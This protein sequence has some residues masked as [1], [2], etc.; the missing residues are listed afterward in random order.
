MAGVC[1]DMTENASLD[2]AHLAAAPIASWRVWVMPVRDEADYVRAGSLGRWRSFSLS[3]R[4][5]AS[6]TCP[7]RTDHACVD[8]TVCFPASYVRRAVK[9]LKL[10]GAEG[11]V[12]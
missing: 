7:T 10:P 11:A 8:A 6:P 12:V 5:A 2:P 3:I 9:V 4:G 1:S